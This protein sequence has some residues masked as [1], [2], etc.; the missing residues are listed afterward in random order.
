[1]GDEPIDAVTCNY[2]EKFAGDITTF[3]CGRILCSESVQG[4]Q[5]ISAS[6]FR[7]MLYEICQKR[8]TLSMQD[9]KLLNEI[10]PM[11]TLEVLNTWLSK[12]GDISN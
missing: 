3:W 1:M 8:K 11:S 7:R 12:L 6:Y 5:I 9:I 4:D 10:V 2:N